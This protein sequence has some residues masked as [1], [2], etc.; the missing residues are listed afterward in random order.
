MLPFIH[1]GGL[2]PFTPHGGGGGNLD[3]IA[4]IRSQQELGGILEQ[5]KLGLIESCKHFN[6]CIINNDDSVLGSNPGLI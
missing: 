2:K 6:F 1:P 4:T 5:L 3:G